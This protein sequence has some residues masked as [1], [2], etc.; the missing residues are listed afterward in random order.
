MDVGCAK[1]SC[2]EI[3]G[4]G[5]GSEPERRAPREAAERSAGTL[6]WHGLKPLYM[7]S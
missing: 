6:A 3:V 4:K 1:D 2:R 7:F 5:T